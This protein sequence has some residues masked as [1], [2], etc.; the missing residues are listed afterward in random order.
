MKRYWF[1]EALVDVSRPWVYHENGMSEDCYKS[2]IHFWLKDL[3]GNISEKDYK[4]LKNYY[5]HGGIYKV[6]EKILKDESQVETI[7][8]Y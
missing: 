8:S 3:Y 2:E 4:K 6:D 5:V 7:N 1:H